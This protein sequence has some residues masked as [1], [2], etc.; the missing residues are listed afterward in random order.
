MD[1]KAPTISRADLISSSENFVFVGFID[2]WS[3]TLDGTERIISAEA[4]DYTSIFLD[5]TFDN[6]S[7]P[8]DQNKRTRKIQLNRQ[9]STIIGDLVSNVQGAENI[10]VEDRTGQA[11]KTLKER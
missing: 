6:A 1:I 8:D 9:I 10:Q 4:R 3:V 5:T 7:L 2:N 11:I